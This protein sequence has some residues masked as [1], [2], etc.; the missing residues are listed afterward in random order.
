[1]RSAIKAGRDQIAHRRF[2]AGPASGPAPEI[3][4]I[5][6]ML[7]DIDFTTIGRGVVQAFAS[8]GDE[9]IAQAFSAAFEKAIN[10]ITGTQVVVANTGKASAR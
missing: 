4:K 10:I 2:L 5:E 8:C 9:I 3:S 1:M 6:D 7:A